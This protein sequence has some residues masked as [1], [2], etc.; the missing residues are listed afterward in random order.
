MKPD[1]APSS[2]S[3][4]D[5]RWRLRQL[6]R[7]REVPTNVWAS[8]EARLNATPQNAFEIRRATQTAKPWRV[9][10]IAASF[11]AVAFIGAVLW[12]NR[13][14]VQPADPQAQM[15]ANQVNLMTLEY[16]AAL[17]ELD[18]AGNAVEMTNADTAAELKLLDDS[19][20]QIRHA[21]TQNPSATYLLSILRRTYMQRLQITQHL[22]IVS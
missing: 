2:A 5:L 18:H 9:L 12:L 17:K 14:E 8:I 7:A 10:A 15:M 1:Q 22:I 20:K 6:P 16:Q 11:T 13:A 3:D 21:I 4:L 19:V